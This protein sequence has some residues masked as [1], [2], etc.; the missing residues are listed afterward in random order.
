M[1]HLSS[2]GLAKLP[3]LVE[4]IGEGETVS[5][6]PPM[7]KACINGRQARLPF[8]ESSETNNY[9]ILELV[10]SDV[11]G[12]MHIPS[13]GGA[14]YVFTFTDHKSRY[15]YCAYTAMKDAAT[16]L[17]KFKE[18]RAWA[19]IQT[20]KK[21]RRVKT[22]Q[23]DGGGEYINDMLKTYLQQEGIEHQYSARYMPQQ[24]GLAERMNRTLLEKTKSMLHGANLP[25]NLWAE[26]WETARYLYAKGPV[27]ALKK[28]TPESMF[29]GRKVK[30]SHL[31]AFGC[32]AYAQVPKKLCKKL[33]PNSEKLIMIG[34]SK[35]VKGYRLWNPIN[36][37]IVVSMDVIFNK[38][39]VGI[40]KKPD[41]K[42]VV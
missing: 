21:I 10:H 9:D 8:I 5:P 14:R 1:G 13:S 41:R 6:T 31:K 23:S 7:C 12:P 4:G 25:Y 32:I 39:M 15:P 19:E 38:A 42:S 18:F 28:D 20:G 30:V 11:C 17:E 29:F 34:Y 33:E 40:D 2:K 24:N 27:T 16:C 35:H 3:N 36:N 37:K 26:T 22:L